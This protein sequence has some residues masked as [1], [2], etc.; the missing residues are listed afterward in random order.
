MKKNRVCF[1]VYVKERSGF[2]KD[3]RTFV[4]KH[5]EDAQRALEE[6]VVS[7]IGTSNKVK[8][9]RAGEKLALYSGYVPFAAVLTDEDKEWDL[10]EGNRSRF[11]PALDD[12]LCDLWAAVNKKYGRNPK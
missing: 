8:I 12:A 4:M 10:S 9:V 5:V 11:L 2:K 3:C 1:A 7:G 6:A